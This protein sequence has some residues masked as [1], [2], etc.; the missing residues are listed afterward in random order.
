MHT[1]LLQE[2]GLTKRAAETYEILLK[3]GESPVSAVIHELKAHPQIAYRAVDELVERGLVTAIMRKYRKYVRA[4]DPRLLMRLQEAKAKELALA[5]PDLMKMRKDSK[6]SIVRVMKGEDAIR[7]LR[8]R[9][10]EELP[11]GGSYYV[12]GASGSRFYDIMGDFFAKLEKKRLEK[13]IKRMN[14][15]FESQREL[16]VK[17]GDQKTRLVEWRYL[18]ESF[19]VP[20]STNIFNDTVAIL[21]W[22]EEPIVVVIESKEIAESYRSYFKALWKYGNK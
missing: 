19:R 17:R 4:E 10:I 15:S 12:I 5:M 11:V 1:L 20:S 2:L 21:V 14:I 6:D 18:P 7:R 9:G 16:V 22:A 13:K 8:A 3:L